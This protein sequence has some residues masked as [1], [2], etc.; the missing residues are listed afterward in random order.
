MSKLEGKSFEVVESQSF[1]DEITDQLDILK[2]K[3]IRIILGNF[4]ATWAR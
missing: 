2:A 1:N 4:N 3:D